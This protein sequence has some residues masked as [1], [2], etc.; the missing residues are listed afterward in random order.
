MTKIKNLNNTSSK[1]WLNLITE[2]LSNSNA[3]STKTIT[4]LLGSENTKYKRTERGSKFLIPKNK[5]L[6]YVAINP[7]LDEN[8]T[9]K[10][11]TFIAFSG[12]N[13]NLKLNYLTELFPNV[14]LVEN[15][16]DG[17]IQLFFNPVN[18]N[19]DFTAVSCDIFTDYKSLD[20]LEEVSINNLSFMFNPDKIKTRAGFTMTA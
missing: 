11:I 15:T 18:S 1:E 5:N 13:L 2:F 12:E 16:Y 4:N 3:Q 17:S 6:N 8:D 20:E 19:F 7:D 14:E 9:D 10:P